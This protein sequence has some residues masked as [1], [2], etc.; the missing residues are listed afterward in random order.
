MRS[1]PG[2]TSATKRPVAVQA[3]ENG[4]GS[5]APDGH[6]MVASAHFTHDGW[7][8]AVAQQPGDAP[9]HSW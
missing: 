1:S 6:G 5:H 2:S 3:Y 4:P 8:S 9:T 7:L